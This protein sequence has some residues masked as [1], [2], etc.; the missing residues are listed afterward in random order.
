[1][2]DPQRS[3]LADV[4]PDDLDHVGRIIAQWSR[5]R[6]DLD[7][8]PMG[9]VGRLHRLAR[10]L[11]DELSPVFE[12]AG[13]CD[14]DFDVLA[15]LRRTGVPYQLSPGRLRETSMVTSGAVS[16]RLDRLEA[17]GLVVRTVDPADARARLVRLTDAGLATV[18]RLVVEHVANEHRLVAGLSLEQRDRLAALLEAWGRALAD[19]PIT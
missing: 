11:D 7:V 6:P 16:K 1:M 14:G 9:L 5:E 8:A 2:D 19:P 15:S 10:A 3:D 18:D 12:A 17:A 4:A 13:L